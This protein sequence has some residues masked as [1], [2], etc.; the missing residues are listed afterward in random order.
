MIK[1]ETDFPIAKD[2]LDHIYPEGVH[3]DNSLNIEFVKQ[4][5]ELFKRKIKFMDLGCAGGQLAC[6]MHERGHIGVGLEGSDHCTN[7]ASFKKM[8][9]VPA[10]Y[11]NW[12]KYHNQ[13]L[14]NCDVTK[15]F[16]VSA[17]A[18]PLSFDLITCWD[19]LEHFEPEQIDMF[20]INV[21]NHLSQDGLFIASLAHSSS[22]RH[23]GFEDTP[24]DL[25]YHRSIF[26]PNEWI[27]KFSKY[28]VQVNYPFTEYNRGILGLV[29]CGKKK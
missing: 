23:P 4:V 20:L 9:G 21:V 25:N 18:E 17:S 12:K 22:G 29:Y 26:A 3:F 11:D 27:E 10:G 14:F 1:V 15:K 24:D 6:T 16:T 5:E 19:V 2:S 7:E 28:L 8:H 13:I